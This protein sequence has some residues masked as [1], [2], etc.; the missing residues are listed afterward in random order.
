V[1]QL[2]LR[3]RVGSAGKL[4]IELIAPSQERADIVKSALDDSGFIAVAT[5]VIASDP[6]PAS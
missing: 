1:G 3:G 2:A 5:I 6:A 4:D